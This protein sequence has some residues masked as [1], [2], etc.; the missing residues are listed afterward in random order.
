MNNPA[1]LTDPDGMGSYDSEGVWHSEMEDFNNYHGLNFDSP[2]ERQFN[3]FSNPDGFGSGGGSNVTMGDLLD[4]YFD[5]QKDK[6]NEV[7]FSQFDFTQFG[8]EN[9]DEPDN[10]YDKNGKKINNN[11]GDTTDYIYDSNGKVIS[12]TSVKFTFSQGGEL[13]YTFEGYGFRHLTIGTGGTLYDPS[14]DMFQAYVGVKELKAGLTLIKMGVTNLSKAELD[15]KVLGNASKTVLESTQY[16]YETLGKARINLLWGKIKSL[17]YYTGVKAG[18]TP[19]WFSFFGRNAVWFG[20][21]RTGAGGVLIY[22]STKR[23]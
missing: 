17:P 4:A 20:G 23:K 13:N 19:N 9:D 2:I 7:D 22:N 5:S 18:W 12:S 10:G 1:N 6:S 16:Y 11:G 21:A 14:M 3:T 8:A 15:H